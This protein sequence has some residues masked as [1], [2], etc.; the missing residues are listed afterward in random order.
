MSNDTNRLPYLLQ[1]Y[2][3]AEGG[4]LTKKR[5]AQLTQTNE[6]LIDPALL[7]LSEHLKGSGLSLITTETEVTLSISA[8]ESEVLRTNYAKDMERE[9]GDAGLEVLSVV[10]Y[11]G[12]STRSQIDY[13]RGVNTSSTIRTLLTRGLI[14][15]T[16]NTLDGREYMYHP[17][18]ELLAHLGVTEVQTLPEYGTILN[19]L[20]ALEATEVTNNPF[21]TSYDRDTSDTSR[22]QSPVVTGDDSNF[23]NDI[24]NNS[25]GNSSSNA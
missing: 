14:E 6:S 19:E 9:I 21:H 10:L 1:A 15:R 17:T 3:F 4:T 5:L 8:T 16:V 12:A 13:I 20:K 24:G 25:G 22:E 23:G 7:A 11:R 2:L 18:P